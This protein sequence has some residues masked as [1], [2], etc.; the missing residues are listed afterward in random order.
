MDDRL[1]RAAGAPCGRTKLATWPPAIDEC[2]I[3]AGNV[4]PEAI[5]LL[6]VAEKSGL[7]D[8]MD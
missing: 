3:V 4:E 8:W 6:C 7:E 2:L 1:C 5:L